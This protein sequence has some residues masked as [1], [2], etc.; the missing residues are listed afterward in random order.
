MAFDV[1]NVSHVEILSPDYAGRRL[2]VI[3]AE[4]VDTG[5]GALNS[6]MMPIPVQL[7]TQFGTPARIYGRTPNSYNPETGTV[8]VDQAPVVSAMVY[9]EAFTVK[10]CDTIPSVQSGDVKLYVPGLAFGFS[11]VALVLMQVREEGA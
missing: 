7:L 10:E 8:A 5:A 1:S 6:L 9:P 11:T 2:A 4:R 3:K